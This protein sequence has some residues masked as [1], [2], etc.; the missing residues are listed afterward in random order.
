LIEGETVAI[1]SFKIRGSNSLK[2]NFNEK[3]LTQHLAYIDAQIN[4]YE[5]QLDAADKQEDKKQVQDK[6]KERKEKHA[7]ADINALK[8]KMEDIL[9][10]VNL[11][12]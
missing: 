8:V 12:T 1:D 3:K 10:V 9:T 6:I 2:N 5:A 4:E 7:Q 11:R